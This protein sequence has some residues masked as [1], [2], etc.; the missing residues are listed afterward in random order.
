MQFKKP[1]HEPQYFIDPN[2]LS[3][4]TVVVNF[5]PDG[6]MLHIF[7][8]ITHPDQ[9]EKTVKIDGV[10]YTKD[11][12]GGFSYCCLITIN[13]WQKQIILNCYVKDHTWYMMK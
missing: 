4:A 11:I 5:A 2:K 1:Y 9:S 7:L 3:P 12:Q 8:R 10:K 6:K 13:N